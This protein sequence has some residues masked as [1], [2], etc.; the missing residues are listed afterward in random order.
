MFNEF[1]Y[2]STEVLFNWILG[3]VKHVLTV[4]LIL[5]HLFVLC[6]LVFFAQIFQ[7]SVISLA[8]HGK[9]SNGFLSKTRFLKSGGY[10]CFITA[11][12]AYQ[13]TSTVLTDCMG[14]KIKYQVYFV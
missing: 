5:L 1:I 12:H 10:N 3:R 13:S 11:I 6:I 2:M 9:L 8:G 4:L 7:V 14:I